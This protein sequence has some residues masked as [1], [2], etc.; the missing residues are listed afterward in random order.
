MLTMPTETEMPH[1]PQ[2]RK[3]IVVCCD[4]TGNKFIDDPDSNGSNSNVVKFY[5]TLRIHNEQVAYYHPGVG[6]SGDPTARN[7]VENFWYRLM[8]LAF[9]RGFKDN[10]LDAYRYLMETYD[11]GDQVYLI[12]FSRGS[13]TVRA[14]AGLLDGYGLLCKGNEGHLPYAWNAYVDQHKMREQ[15]FVEHDITFKETFSR[16][17]FRIHF[18]GIWDT[19]SSV[20]WIKTPL[21]LFNVAQNPTIKIGRHAVSIDERRCFYR[22]NLWELATEAQLHSV[23]SEDD[24]H[25]TQNLLAVWFPGAHSDVGGSYAQKES[26]LSNTA[27][28]WMLDEACRAGIQV[29]WHMRELV[30]GRDAAPPA[31]EPDELIRVKAL[32]P[33]YLEPTQ[34]KVHRSLK[35]IW[36]LL[37]F[38][39]HRYYDKDDGKEQLRI[40]LGMRR[41]I[42]SGNTKRPDG[43]TLGRPD[44]T[45]LAVPTYIHHT[46]RT[47]ME[48]GKYRAKNILDWENSLVDEDVEDQPKRS[49]LAY[50]PAKDA[51][52]WRNGWLVRWTVIIVVTLA[53]VAVVLLLLMLVAL[54][55]RYIAFPVAVCL[56]GVVVRPLLV[57]ILWAHIL[58]P[59]L[60]FFTKLWKLLPDRTLHCCVR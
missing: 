4:G 45:K 46:A 26:V 19:V 48:A 47:M 11:D 24:P 34:T 33:L 25:P 56:W 32:R 52:P 42:P 1:P 27:L 2:R 43:T 22:D 10:V 9:A 37:E 16:R 35:K 40:P 49:L 39:P 18:M 12:G 59:V 20:G 8:G 50:K 23:R 7:R 53:D 14:L 41:R 38:I 60:L 30:L 17:K 54:L 13:Y 51:Q 55:L 3:N 28:E 57:K 15:I 6:T 44:G 58:K 21:R 31:G 5:S 29:K 36:W